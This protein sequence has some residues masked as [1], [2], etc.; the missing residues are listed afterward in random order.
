MMVA[1]NARKVTP[2]ASAKL[3]VR[4]EEMLLASHQS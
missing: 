3:K 2:E 4:E 1:V